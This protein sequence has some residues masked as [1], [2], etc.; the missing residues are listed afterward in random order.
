MLVL[1]SSEWHLFT[2]KN[3][4]LYTLEMHKLLTTLKE[5]VRSCCLPGCPSVCFECA[6]PQRMR[7]A[8]ESCG[9]VPRRMLAGARC[10][11]LA[12]FLACKHRLLHPRATPAPPAHPRLPQ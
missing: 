10:Q 8:R 3:L 5:N 4:T 6:V 7:A 12:S 1:G 11:A 2:Q 9:H